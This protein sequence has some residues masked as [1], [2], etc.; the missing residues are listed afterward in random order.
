MAMKIRWAKQEERTGKIEGFSKMFQSQSQLLIENVNTQY[1]VL[2]INDGLFFPVTINDTEWDNSFVCSPYSAYAEYTKEEVKWT[3]KNVVLRVF[4]LFVIKS[5]SGWL[6]RGQLN[7][8][9]HV[10][11]FLLSTN[12]FPEWNGKEI[13]EITAF[14]KSEYP[15]HAIVFRSLNEYQHGDLLKIFE[16]NRFDTIGSRQVYI[17]DLT[18]GDWLKHRNNKHDNKLIKKVGLKFIEHNDMEAHLPQALKLYRKL[19]L[20]KY[21]ELNPQFTLK[22]FQ[23]SYASGIINFQG[24]TDDHGFLKAFSGQ[25][26]LDNTVTSPL[27]GYDTSAPRKEGLY[28]HAA[29]LAI[30]SKFKLGLL[31]NLSSGAP[32][33]K[34]MRGGVPSI[35]YSA[36]YINHLS[37]KRRLRWSVLKFISNKIGVPLIKKYKL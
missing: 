3:I 1:R 24:Y 37:K 13:P 26:T 27:V 11:N 35:E 6:K 8:N 20:E 34:R 4:L 22:Y 31:L 21:S 16:T 9:V 15:N 14:L 32:E 23:E 25:F 18:K 10:N 5:I 19:Y 29:Q 28:I 12:P 2:R 36:L 7:K 30:L 33:F 17:F